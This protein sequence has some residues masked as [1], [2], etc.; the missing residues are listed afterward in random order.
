[1]AEAYSGVDDLR[2]CTHLCA[3][4]RYTPS[5]TKCEIAQNAV[6]VVRGAAIESV[7][8]VLRIEHRLNIVLDH[9][10][11]LDFVHDLGHAFL[12]RYFGV[13]SSMK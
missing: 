11:V 2:D 3:I 5:T 12:P 9:D 4:P 1:M 7:H 10:L 8:H 13:H 6:M